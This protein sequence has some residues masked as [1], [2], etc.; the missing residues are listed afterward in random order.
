MDAELSGSLGLLALYA[1]IALGFSF[2]CSIAVAV[3][4]S[5]GGGGLEASQVHEDSG[6]EGTEPAR[7]ASLILPQRGGG[8]NEPSSPGPERPMV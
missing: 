2:L 8:G 7:A 5:D 4:L 6:R 1:V 3:L